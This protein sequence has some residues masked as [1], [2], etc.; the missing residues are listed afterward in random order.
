MRRTGPLA[1][2]TELFDFSAGK[3]CE[4][5]LCG[6]GV[7]G[8]GGAGGAAALDATAGGAVTVARELMEPGYYAVT[9][10]AASPNGAGFAGTARL[11]LSLTLSRVVDLD[12]AVWPRVITTGVAPGFYGASV[13]F[14]VSTGYVVENPDY[15][16]PSGEVRYDELS[17]TFSIPGVFPSGVSGMTTAVTADIG[18]AREEDLCD[19]RKLTVTAIFYPVTDPGQA[20]LTAFY[21]ESFWRAARPPTGY[22]SGGRFTL[23]GVS[24]VDAASLSAISLRVDSSGALTLDAAGGLLLAGIATATIE[25]TH[26]DFFGT[27]TLR[28]RL[29]I[30]PAHP[31][32]PY[33]LPA[34]HRSPPA[35]TGCGELAGSCASGVA[36]RSGGGR[37]YHSAAGVAAQCFAGAFR[38]RADGV[39]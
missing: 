33:E 6:G 5:G 7:F 13:S 19:V 24:G 28:T 20:T 2:G 18:C 9:V 37:R 25:M 29:E 26:P 15:D 31:G 17:R 38:R 23:L 27:V 32:L 39:V 11:T 3:L 30:L 14:M 34:A 4:R 36:G 8:V 10:L 35:V 12:E 22:E 21:G 16:F 1:A